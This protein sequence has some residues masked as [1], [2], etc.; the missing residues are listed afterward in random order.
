MDHLVARH[1]T[2]LSSYT[3]GGSLDPLSHVQVE[4]LRRHCEAH[5]DERIRLGL[6]ISINNGIAAGSRNSG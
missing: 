5:D 4:L 6:L 3:E 2:A 1:T